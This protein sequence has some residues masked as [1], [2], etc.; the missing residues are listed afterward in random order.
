MHARVHCRQHTPYQKF[1]FALVHGRPHLI[2]H[3]NMLHSVS[4]QGASCVNPLGTISHIWKS[5][6]NVK[7]EF[8]MISDS[9]RYAFRLGQISLERRLNL[10]L[11]LL[12][13]EMQRLVFN[14]HMQLQQKLQTSL[15]L[16]LFSCVEGVC[17]WRR[18]SSLWRNRWRQRQVSLRQL[19]CSI[20][21]S[22]LQHHIVYS[23]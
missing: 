6:L 10:T 5:F 8:W 12:R 18:Q 19:P 3:H 1:L 2:I 22:V 16:F 7:A 17:W 20:Y 13:V 21:T 11:L 14:N 23:L 4:I 9:E 15:Y